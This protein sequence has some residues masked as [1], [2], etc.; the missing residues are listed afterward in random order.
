MK[1]CVR[2]RPGAAIQSWRAALRSPWGLL[3]A[4]LGAREGQA[5]VETVM[6]T[7][8]LVAL[9]L[10]LDKALGPIVVKAFENVAKALSSVGP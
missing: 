5:V 3:R 9:A 2:S 8:F 1:P 6:T 4:K 10:V 7:G